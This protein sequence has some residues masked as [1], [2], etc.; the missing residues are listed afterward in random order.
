IRW[1]ATY[2]SGPRVQA[3]GAV[4][5]KGRPSAV[6]WGI[7]GT[8]HP[9]PRRS[10][11]GRPRRARSPTRRQSPQ[12]SRSTPTRATTRRARRRRSSRKSAGEGWRAREVEEWKPGTYRHTSD[13][14]PPSV[15]WVGARGKGCSSRRALYPTVA[16]KLRELRFYLG[17]VGD[18]VRISY[19]IAS[20]RRIILL[21]VFKKQRG[22][23]RAEVDRAA[24]AMRRCIEEAHDTGD[25]SEARFGLRHRALSSRQRSADSARESHAGAPPRTRARAPSRR[26][27]RRGPG[28]CHCPTRLLDL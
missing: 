18:A 10:S 26:R 4:A 6:R 19:Y 15:M 1:T 25:D 8:A 20:G 27:S 12:S 14:M 22:R 24:R 13:D 3:R 2:G 11:S 23:E 17:P 9:Q 5:H 16:G 21:T 7:L 28:P